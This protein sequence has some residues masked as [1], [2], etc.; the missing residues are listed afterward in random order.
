MLKVEKKAEY[1]PYLPFFDYDYGHGYGETVSH[2]TIKFNDSI[3]FEESMLFWKRFLPMIT[4]NMGVAL[5]GIFDSALGRGFHPKRM[6][7]N[8]PAT[9]LM[10]DDGTKGVSKRHKNDKDKPLVGILNAALRR[11]VGNHGKVSRYWKVVKALG[12]MSP[13]VTPTEIRDL[14]ASLLDVADVLDGKCESR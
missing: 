14:A 4:E 2:I 9:I 8:G 11:R 10:Y 5:T 7:R 12:K 1:A 3:T 6:F 13:M